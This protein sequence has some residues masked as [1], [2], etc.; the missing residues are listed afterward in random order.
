M[1]SAFN[2]LLW[3]LLFIVCL[4]GD[5]L[6][7]C[8]QKCKFNPDQSTPYGNFCPDFCSHLLCFQAVASNPHLEREST[9]ANLYQFLYCRPFVMLLETYK[10]LFMSQA[11]SL[12]PTS[13]NH[14]RPIPMHDNLKASCS[15][16]YMTI[17]AISTWVLSF[18]SCNQMD[19]VLWTLADL[20]TTLYI[21]CDMHDHQRHKKTHFFVI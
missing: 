15:G 5:M 1:W 7:M 18:A 20:C 16:K 14:K 17:S 11:L 12:P 19:L 3:F 13:G 8:S 2:A 6:A 9:Q 4:C 10:S 21:S